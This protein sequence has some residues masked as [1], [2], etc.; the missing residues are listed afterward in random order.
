MSFFYAKSQ[1]LMSRI[2]DFIE[3]NIIENMYCVNG[4]P[5]INWSLVRY[6]DS[7][8]EINA[9]DELDNL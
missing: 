6:I 5:V 7:L 8:E 4:A 2:C 1:S 3:K 9:T